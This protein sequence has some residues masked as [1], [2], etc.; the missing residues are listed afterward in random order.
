MGFIERINVYTDGGSKGNPG[1]GSIGVVVCDGDNNLLYEFSECIGHCTN[2]QA[3]YRALIKGLDLCAKYTRRQVTAY[4]DSE[5]VVK[6]MNGAYRLK[7]DK[8]RELY[9][10]VK[11]RERVFETVTYQ[12]VSRSNQRIARADKLLNEAHAGRPTDKRIVGR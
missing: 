1:A 11:D 2:N 6:Q 10:K 7:N 8:L 5:L 4:C 3:E 9:H 12:H